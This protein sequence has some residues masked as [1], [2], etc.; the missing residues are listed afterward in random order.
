M[1]Y[2]SKNN[3]T[4]EEQYCDPNWFFPDPDQDPTFQI[5]F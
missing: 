2:A 4:A 1:A 3:E 5:I